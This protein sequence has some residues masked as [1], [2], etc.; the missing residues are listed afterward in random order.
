[1]EIFVEKRTEKVQRRE[2]RMKLGLDGVDFRLS[3]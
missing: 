3:L 2:T 1:V